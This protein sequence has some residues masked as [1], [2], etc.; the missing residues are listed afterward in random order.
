MICSSLNLL[1]FMFCC[2]LPSPQNSSFVTSRFSGSGQQLGFCLRRHV[3]GALQPLQSR[4]LCASTTRFY[5][6]FL[7]SGF[8]KTIDSSSSD[9]NIESVNRFIA[10]FEFLDDQVPPLAANHS[11]RDWLRNDKTAEL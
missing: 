3:I 6:V 9:G 7:G 2:S 11:L 4:V 8:L 10:E 1:F 5:L